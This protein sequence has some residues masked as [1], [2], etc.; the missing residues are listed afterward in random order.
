MYL[1]PVIRIGWPYALGHCG[2]SPTGVVSFP[3]WTPMTNQQGL[4]FGPVGLPV[5]KVSL[6]A[7][8]PPRFSPL[9]L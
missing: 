9:K 2:V 5:V 4:M 7:S 1:R 6:L 8:S 3:P